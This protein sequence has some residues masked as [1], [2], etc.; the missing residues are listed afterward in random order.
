MTRKGYLYYLYLIEI[1]KNRFLFVVIIF[2][3]QY[4]IA[5]KI[6]F[7]HKSTKNFEAQGEIILSRL[8]ILIQMF[9]A[10]SQMDSQSL[11]DESTLD[12]ASPQ[13]TVDDDNRSSSSSQDLLQSMDEIS[14]GSMSPDTTDRASPLE[15]GIGT[16]SPP[17]STDRRIVKRKSII[18]PQNYLEPCSG[19]PRRR[20]FINLYITVQFDMFSWWG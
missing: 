18:I 17:R 7:Y 9:T 3:S 13:D 19:L 12:P 5:K 15:S 8:Q 4:R 14:S 16:A 1:R 20:F 2:A 10:E 6:H 11:Q